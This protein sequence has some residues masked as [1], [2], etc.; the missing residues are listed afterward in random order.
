ME[1]TLRAAQGK[2]EYLEKDA[3][4]Y[5]ERYEAARKRMLEFVEASDLL[6]ES[7]ERI[8]RAV[9]SYNTTST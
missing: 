4:S 5:R 7:Q 9:A 1:R 3:R 2:C 6:R 8:D